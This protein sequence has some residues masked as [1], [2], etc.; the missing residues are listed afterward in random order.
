MEDQNEILVPVLLGIICLMFLILAIS[1]IVKYVNK[2]KKN[3]KNKFNLHNENN[4]SNNTSNQ[5]GNNLDSNLTT[6][7]LQDKL[8]RTIEKYE[9]M[10]NELNLTYSKQIEQLA[11]IAQ[12]DVNQAK[13][14]LLS[15]LDMKLKKE[16]AQLINQYADITKS[17]MHQKIENMLINCF[18]TLNE[19][20][21]VPKTSFTIKL[22]D[23]AVKGRII[24]KDG[25]NKKSFELITGTDLIIEKEPEITISC[26]NPIRREIAKNVLIK[27]I[28]N[29]H[30]EPS[31]IEKYFEQESLMIEH[32]IN[33]IGADVIENQLQIFDLNKELYSYV[34]RLYFRT[35]YG[36]NILLHSKECAM[37]A[38]GIAREI[39]VDPQKAKKAA[40]FHDI[41][42]SIDFDIDNDHVE[43]GLKIA[44]K[45]NLDD[46]II[47]AI[48]SHHEKVPVDNI[49]SAIVKVVDKISA[50]RPGARMIS[51]EEYIQRVNAIESICNSFDGVKSSYALKAG[52]QVRVII[53]P[54]I[55]DDEQ[56]IVLAH[57]IKEKLENEPLINKQPVDVILIREKRVEIKS[58]G[59]AARSA[60]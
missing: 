57:D 35:S 36:Q 1:L 15:N 52:R 21:I 6:K 40:F 46:Y 19:E 56:A 3:R 54:K 28:E 53:D 60:K 2:I 43:S 18:E 29:K 25:R 45:Y 58:D 44:R 48:E 7:N 5:L 16:K 27:L 4:L 34:G 42:K 55:L 11:H 9:D 47:N 39:G 17:E 59:S 50:S 22:E 33:Q 20:F 13:S 24:G 12:M 14:L 38:V 37:L 23:D 41:G 31:R 32:K 8:K 10:Q 51:F 26:F 30:I 49:Y